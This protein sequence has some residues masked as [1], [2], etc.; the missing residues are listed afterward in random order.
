[1]MARGEQ[2]A[3]GRLA[4]VLGAGRSRV[5]ITTDRPLVAEALLAAARHR[6]RREGDLV[7]VDVPARGDAVADIIAELTRAG[8][9]LSEV[10]CC[11]PTLEDLY[12]DLTGSRDPRGPAPALAA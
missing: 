7:V 9:R 2:L 11:T 5:E 1:V 10:R 12:L 4:D 3:Q 6:V 8:V